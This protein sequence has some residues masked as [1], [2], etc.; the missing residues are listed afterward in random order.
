[1]GR[2]GFPT[3]TT[4]QLPRCCKSSYFKENI[5]LTSLAESRLTHFSPMLYFYTPPL[6]HLPPSPTPENFRTLLFFLRFQGFFRWNIEVKW[7][8]IINI[9]RCRDSMFSDFPFMIVSIWLT[10]FP[11]NG[12]GNTYVID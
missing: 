11:S 8:N 9:I 2:Q 5:W 6:P 12:R 1:M 3:L 10:L 7:V 4:F